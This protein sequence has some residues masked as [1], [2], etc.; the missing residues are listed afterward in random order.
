MLLG[1]QVSAHRRVSAGGDLAAQG[2]GGLPYPGARGTG[3]QAF[4]TCRASGWGQTPSPVGVKSLG[5][6]QEQGRPGLG[7]G[8]GHIL[9]G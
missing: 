2:V 8:L 6:G 7:L 9:A 3:F 4:P 1:R 5:R